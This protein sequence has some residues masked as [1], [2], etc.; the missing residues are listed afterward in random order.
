VFDDPAVSFALGVP[1]SM[2]WSPVLFHEGF[3]KDM[4]MDMPELYII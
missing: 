3:L 1:V 2:S 4:E